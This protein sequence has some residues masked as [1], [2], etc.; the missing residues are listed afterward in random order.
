MARLASTMCAGIVLV[1]SLAAEGGAQATKTAP[2]GVVVSNTSRAVGDGRYDWT[3]S[4]SGP[5]VAADQIQCVEYT[6]HPTFPNPVRRVC[7]RGKDVKHAFALSSNGW[8]EFTIKLRVT[9]RNGTEQR[10]AYPLK[11]TQ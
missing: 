10:L 5:R 6:L 3:V 1:A 4:I 11:L 8:G 9:F 2:P 7:T